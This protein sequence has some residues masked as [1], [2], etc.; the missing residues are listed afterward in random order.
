MWSNERSSYRNYFYIAWQKHLQ[1]GIFL[2]PL[3]AQIVEIIK[4]HPEYHFI[5]ADEKYQ[6]Q[7]YFPELGENNPFLHLSLHLGLHEQLATNRP[8]GIREIYDKLVQKVKDPHE[9]QHLMMARI[10]E[11]MF[12][13]SRGMPFDDVAYLAELQNLLRLN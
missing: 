12:R 13:A 9:A 11:M 8:Q 6:D 3:E 1:A 5:F 10:N 2:T 7:D 4:M